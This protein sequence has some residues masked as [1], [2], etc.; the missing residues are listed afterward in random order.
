VVEI[1]EDQQ[2]EDDLPALFDEPDID[3]RNDE[4]SRRF[5]PSAAE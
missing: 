3:I 2:C 5:H 1:L 4:I